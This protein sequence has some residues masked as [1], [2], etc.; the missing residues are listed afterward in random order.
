MDEIKELLIAKFNEILRRTLSV[1]DQLG[2]E[3][4]NWRPN[5]SSNSIANLIVH[6][7]GNVKERILNGILHRGLTR[8][9]DAEFEE[10]YKSKDELIEITKETYQTIVDTIGN[11]PEETWKKTQLVRNKERTNLDMIIQCATHFSEHLGQM[12]YIGKLIKDKD[13]V[14]TSIPKKK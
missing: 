10:L 11:M 2:D 6:V 14:V 3:E 5:E 1:I 8:N 4:L 9:R 7:Q 12:M 13:Y